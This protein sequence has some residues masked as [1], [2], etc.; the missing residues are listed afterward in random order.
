[1]LIFA[2][3]IQNGGIMKTLVTSQAADTSR[4]SRLANA[5]EYAK[6]QGW[7]PM[8]PEEKAEFMKVVAEFT[9]L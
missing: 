3:E 7:E 1:M 5:R 8:K 2:S 4:Y 6:Q 9:N